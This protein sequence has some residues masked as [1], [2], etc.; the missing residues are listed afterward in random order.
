MPYLKLKDVSAGKY[1]NIPDTERKPQR[2][3]NTAAE[4]MAGTFLR[5]NLGYDY[6]LFENKCNCTSDYAICVCDF[7]R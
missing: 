4:S 6:K 5:G 3:F 2:F 1:T 7:K